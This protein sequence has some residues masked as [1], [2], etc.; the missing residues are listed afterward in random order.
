MDRSGLAPAPMLTR[1]LI[2]A[3]DAATRALVLKQLDGLPVDVFTLQGR[4]SA[5]EFARLAAPDVVILALRNADDSL[6]VCHA[7]AQMPELASIQVAVVCHLQPRR[8]HGRAAVRHSGGGLLVLIATEAEGLSQIV[9]RAVF[10]EALGPRPSG[11][12]G[13]AKTHGGAM[14]PAEPGGPA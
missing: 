11:E 13:A 3:D 9:R 4:D 5:L 1:V 2:A 10:G 8:S 7:I 12:E 6:R 14:A